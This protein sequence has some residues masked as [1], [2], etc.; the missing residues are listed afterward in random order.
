MLMV[1][2]MVMVMVQ[3]LFEPVAADRI[4]QSLPLPLKLQLTSPPL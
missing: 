1:M 4:I 2:V 3:Y